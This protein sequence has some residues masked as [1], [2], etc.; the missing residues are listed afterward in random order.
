MSPSSVCSW[1]LHRYICAEVAYLHIQE[2]NLYFKADFWSQIDQDT[3]AE[4][5]QIKRGV[6]NIDL[7]WN[8]EGIKLA[9]NCVNVLHVLA[10]QIQFE[11]NLYGSYPHSVPDLINLITLREWCIKPTPKS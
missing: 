4:V 9:R 10:H 3:D 5:F 7:A 8:Y 1:V 11:Y 2:N 6:S